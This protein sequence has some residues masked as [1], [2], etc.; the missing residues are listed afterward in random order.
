MMT[1]VALADVCVWVLA[2]KQDIGAV[3][4]NG[5]VRFMWV[6]IIFLIGWVP[7][8]DDLLRAVARLGGGEAVSAIVGAWERPRQAPMG[9]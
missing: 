1:V 9:L 8:G 5:R 7:L 2:W 6:P 4:L 3:A